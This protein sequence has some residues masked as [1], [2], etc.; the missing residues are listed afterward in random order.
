VLPELTI[1]QAIL[2]PALG[3]TVGALG[4][5]VGV[6]G[7]FLIVPSLL[8]IYPDAEPSAITSM[9]L[10]AVAI[11]AASAS[12]GYRRRRWQ[13]FRTG[14]ILIATAVPAAI[15]GAL[16]TR[17]TARGTFDLAFGVALLLG[18]GYL[19][20]RGGTLPTTPLPS[21]RG[22]PRQIVDRAGTV[23]RY[24]VREEIAAVVAVVAG[25]VA[26]FFGIGGGIINVPVMML[27]LRMPSVIAVATS[28]MELMV[29]SSAAVIV[30][31]A[32]DFGNT[33]VWLRAL[34]LGSGTLI[35]AQLGVH[36]GGRVSGRLV[37]LII[38]A[39]L[40]LAGVR[41]VFAGIT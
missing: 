12:V 41:Q 35:G 15:A 33:N 21:E 10:T 22:R 39:G 31:L 2:L 4:A 7:G 25:F 3:F 6:G 14:A 18:A 17:V 28:Q 5:M 19:A 40:L 30:H 16:L 37:L 1:G 9:S 32:F 38:S 20:W 34:I 24:R 8:I 26:A 11:N 23:Y 36:M 13:D 27:A 29:A